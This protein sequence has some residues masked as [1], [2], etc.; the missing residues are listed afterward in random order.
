MNANF[1]KD[2]DIVVADSS[3]RRYITEE[4]TNMGKGNISAQIFAFRELC[5]ATQNFQADNLIGEGGFGRVYKGTLEN[6][7]EVLLQPHIFISLFSLLLLLTTLCF[8]SL[9]KFM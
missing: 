1:L 7:S 6:K 9:M 8:S 4:I 3:R 2:T 5:V